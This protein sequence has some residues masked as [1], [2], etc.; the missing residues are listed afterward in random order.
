MVRVGGALLVC[1]R[2][3]IEGAVLLH[4]QVQQL[5]EQHAVLGDAVEG[6]PADAHQ[7][8][9]FLEF[10]L[11]AHLLHGVGKALRQLG[12]VLLVQRH[13]QLLGLALDGGIEADVALRLLLCLLNEGGALQLLV[14]QEVPVLVEHLLIEA[15]IGPVHVQVVL[16]RAARIGGPVEIGLRR[17]CHIPHGV[18]RIP[19]VDAGDIVEDAGG[20][21]LFGAAR[22]Q[23]DNQYQGH[24][25]AA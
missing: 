21:L 11:A 25:P 22:R 7:L 10:L 9:I 15:V 18:G 19:G 24:Q 2:S 3:H 8:Q 23:R 20:R 6:L 13:A 14:P 17:E 4:H 16:H 5:L 12:P 1:L